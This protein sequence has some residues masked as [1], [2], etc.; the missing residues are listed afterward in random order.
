MKEIRHTGLV[1]YDLE[2]AIHFYRDILGLKVQRQMQE[3]GSFIDNLLGIK[4]VRL[5]TVKMAAGD[6]G[7]LELLNFQSSPTAERQRRINQIGYSHIA[8]TVD[9]LEYEYQRLKKIGIKFDSA[10][11]VSPDKLARV[12]FCRD[13][14]GNHIEL[15]QMIDKT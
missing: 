7:L 1:V 5:K 15:V 6:G 10:P 4:G 9:D 14:E 2:K 11:Q 8:F 13:P 3:F 12:V